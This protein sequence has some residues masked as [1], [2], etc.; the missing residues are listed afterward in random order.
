MAAAF[1]RFNF[2]LLEPQRPDTC[3]DEGVG[4]MW[5]LGAS[6]STMP[7]VREE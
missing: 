5:T 1:A 4:R 2:F 3:P 7:S 6:S